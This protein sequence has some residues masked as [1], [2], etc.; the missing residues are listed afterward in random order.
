MAKKVL[1]YY[2]VILYEED[3]KLFD[4]YNW[5]NDQC[6]DFYIEPALIYLISNAAVF[7]S[8]IFFMI[9]NNNLNVNQP[10]GGT[11]WSLLIYVKGLN[12]FFHF[13][14][15]HNMN[16]KIAKFNALKF[17][18]IIKIQDKLDVEKLLEISRDDVLP[19]KI[20]RENLRNL[21]GTLGPN[22]TCYL[23]GAVYLN[24]ERLTPI[25]SVHLDLIGIEKTC[26]SNVHGRSKTV[27][28]G[29][30]VLENH[31]S[32]ELGSVNYILRATV[33]KKVFPFLKSPSSPLSSSSLSINI[34]QAVE[35]LCPLKRT[36]ILDNEDKNNIIH[37][38]LKGKTKNGDIEYDFMLPPNKILNIDEYE[39]GCFHEIEFFIPNNILPTYF[40]KFITISHKLCFKLCLWGDSDLLIKE[41][42]KVANIINKIK[43]DLPLPPSPAQ[44]PND[45]INSNFLFAKK[46]ITQS[47]IE[48]CFVNFKGNEIN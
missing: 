29:E 6:I 41:D 35:I 19:A 36:L 20:M 37:Y 32:T 33:S 15:C 39:A 22:H 7:S 21:K 46:S 11:H 30:E 38:N 1:S 24:Y 34:N 2:D 26:W 17:S 14:S 28:N 45:D 9:I 40:G 4:D 42:V 12:T 44:S 43:V 27:Y 13:D 23:I 10:R 5:I 47:Q 16:E 8:E 31:F 3:V 18:E 48:D 25:K